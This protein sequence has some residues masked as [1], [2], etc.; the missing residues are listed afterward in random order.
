M[1]KIWGINIINKS[2]IW[3]KM[4]IQGPLTPLRFSI[5]NRILTSTSL[6][7]G[8]FQSLQLHLQEKKDFLEVIWSIPYWSMPSDLV[9]RQIEANLVSCD[10]PPLWAPVTMQGSRIVN[11]D[12]WRLIRNNASHVYYAVY[13]YFKDYI[14]RLY[15]YTFTYWWSLQHLP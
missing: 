15:G 14:L 5:K 3:V 12:L 13:S 4:Q 9:L 6:S 8:S 1:D 11:S 7:T 2:P 10:P